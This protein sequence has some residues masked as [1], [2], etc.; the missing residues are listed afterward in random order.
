M[1]R[2]VRLSRHTP[3]A[4]RSGLARTSPVRQARPRPAVPTDVRAIVVARS[5][6]RCE[7]GLPGCLG[8]GTMTHH[9]QL[10]QAGGKRSEAARQRSNRAANLLDVCPVCHDAIHARPAESYEAG[11]LLP[12]TADAGTEPVQTTHD[13]LPIFLDD[14]GRWFRFEQVGP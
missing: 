11:L 5:K 3:L 7:A 6:G 8:A 10:R 2:H 14:S 13:P 1:I 4:A 12:Q 9:R